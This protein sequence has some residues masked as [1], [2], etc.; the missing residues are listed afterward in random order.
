MS[1]SDAAT[2]IPPAHAENLCCLTMFLP[3]FIVVVGAVTPYGS[4]AINGHT[5]TLLQKKTGQWSHRQETARASCKAPKDLMTMS[6]GKPNFTGCNDLEALSQ[7]IAQYS[8]S[9]GCSYFSYI[10]IRGSS[11]QANIFL[12]NYDKEWHERY[13]RKLYKHYDPVAVLTKRSRLPFF[14]NQRD[15]LRPFQK[16]QRKVFFEA[17]AFRISAGYSVP[18]AGPN[19]DLGVF[20]IADSNESALVDAVRADSA[21]IIRSALHA[22]DHA[23]ELS[24]TSGIDQAPEQELTAREL[25]CLKWTAEGKTTSEIADEMMISAATVNYHAKKSIAKLNAANRHHAAIIAIRAGLV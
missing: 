23:M 12:S 4:A 17:R 11:D 2:S 5:L 1:S 14:W 20:T 8:A 6:Q 7:S 3:C 13:K 15:F 24:R 25:E 10:M 21:E 19:G 18:V 9:L 22:H 16:I